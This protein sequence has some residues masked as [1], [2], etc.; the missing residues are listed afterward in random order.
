MTTDDIIKMAKEYADEVTNGYGVVTYEFDLY[1]L[2]KFALL[3]RAAEREACAKLQ[4]DLAKVGEVGVWGEQD[5]ENN[6]DKS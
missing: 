5:K 1:G 6:D 3:I 4:P 2:E